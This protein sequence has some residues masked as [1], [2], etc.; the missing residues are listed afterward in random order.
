[1]QKHGFETSNI[2]FIKKIQKMLGIG[3]MQ[4]TRKHFLYFFV[5][6]TSITVSRN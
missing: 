3:R 4:H 5:K 6:N 2:F 1:M